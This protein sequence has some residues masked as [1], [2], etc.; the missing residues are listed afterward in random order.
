MDKVYVVIEYDHC[1][2]PTSERYLY[3]FGAEKNAKEKVEDLTRNN[4]IKSLDYDYVV[5]WIM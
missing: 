3:I 4:L 5:D 1:V 2:T